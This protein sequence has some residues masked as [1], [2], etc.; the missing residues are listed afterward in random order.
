MSVCI[1]IAAL[2]LCRRIVELKDDSFNSHIVYMNLFRPILNT[3]MAN[4]RYN[5]VNSAILEF[6]EYIKVVRAT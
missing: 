6:F 4:G 2:R 3:L 5:L 1:Y